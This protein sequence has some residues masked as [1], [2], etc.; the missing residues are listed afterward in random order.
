MRGSS[1][2]LRLSLAQGFSSKNSLQI[3]QLVSLCGSDT[4]SV[5]VS[6]ERRGQR[7]VAHIVTGIY[8]QFF[9]S[10]NSHLEQCVDCERGSAS[11]DKVVVD[12][13]P[14]SMTTLNNA[15][16]YIHGM[17][18]GKQTRRILKSFPSI[19]FCIRQ[20][21]HGSTRAKLPNSLRQRLASYPRFRLL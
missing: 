20:Q 18:V 17:F 6:V 2:S 9:K 4:V 21:G 11:G 10:K 19:C 13:F 14:G 7:P 12:A 15:P 5:R 16:M 8:S 3:G 1:F